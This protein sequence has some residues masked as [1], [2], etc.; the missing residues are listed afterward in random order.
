MTA[1]AGALVEAWDELRMHRLRVLLSLIG[2][3]VSVSTMTAV[4]AIG[5]L[6]S[7]AQTE[8]LERESGRQ[9]TITV[10]AWDEG[11]PVDTAT[12]V[13]QMRAVVKRFQV[14]HSSLRLAVHHELR[15]GAVSVPAG[16]ELVDEAFGVIHRVQ[17]TDGSWFSAADRDRL[18]PA[19]VVNQAFL[20]ALGVG[21]LADRPTVVMPGPDP[22]TMVII[23]TVADQW[24]HD[25]PA[26]YVLYDSFVAA[27]AHDPQLSTLP[28]LELW[29]P[30]ELADDG[31]AVV[32]SHLSAA[33]GPQVT[34]DSY[35]NDGWGQEEFDDTFQFIVLGIGVV[36]LLLGAL[37]LV[38]IALVSLRQRIREIGIRR[39]FG[40][41]ST[42]VF[43]AVMMES[44]VATAL[45]G[46]AGVALAV[47][48]VQRLPIAEWL[49]LGVQDHPAFPLEVAVL[50]M[51]AAVGVGAVA[52][53]VPALVA[54]RIKPIDA[55]RY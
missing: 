26:G 4:M 35:R 12:M 9:T 55:I 53:L 3:A 47:V 14:E 19:L 54:V 41:T 49:A 51:V 43:F 30:P 7:Q 2:V 24:E 21:D 50:G 34:V 32:R 40:A 22:V 16:L 13:E 29:V 44:V 18:A 23:G 1:L 27:A 6:T 28:Q 11:S 37:S 25:E 45:A 10:D 17:L 48:V 42:R 38:N 33:L 39:S 20:T 46:V 36:V 5:Q 8:L 15:S 31:E 52:G